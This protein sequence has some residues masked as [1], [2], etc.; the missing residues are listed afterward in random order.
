MKG[1]TES[2]KNRFVEAL[3]SFTSVDNARA[4]VTMCELTEFK[5][6][7]KIVLSHSNKAVRKEA[8][9][10]GGEEVMT[11]RPEEQGTQTTLCEYVED[12]KGLVETTLEDWAVL[13]QARQSVNQ[14]R[15]V[16]RCTMS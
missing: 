15:A 10:L 6:V 3:E 13:C 12:S 8:V 4:L 16:V 9:V 5:D 2:S 1:L 14:R 7:R 11:L